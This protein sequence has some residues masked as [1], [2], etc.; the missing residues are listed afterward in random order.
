MR[1][2]PIPSKHI[3][4]KYKCQNGAP[5]TFLSRILDASALSFISR[6]PAVKNGFLPFSCFAAPIRVSAAKQEKGRLGFGGHFP[7]LLVLRFSWAIIVLPF[8]PFARR[9]RRDKQ[10]GRWS[11]LAADGM[12]LSCEIWPNHAATPNRRHAWYFPTD[13]I[14]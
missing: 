1:L 6:E 8:S 13:V 7:R 3:L 12:R 11:L 10:G 2:H 9:L 14:G 5:S 4:K